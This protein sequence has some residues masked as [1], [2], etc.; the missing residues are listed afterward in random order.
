MLTLAGV[1]GCMG[2]PRSLRLSLPLPFAS[3][4]ATN[5]LEAN[6]QPT[7]AKT[8]SSCRKSRASAR[9]PRRYPLLQ[10]ALLGI[11]DWLAHPHG[12]SCCVAHSIG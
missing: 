8:E 7:Q 11:G 6:P 9:Y 3:R 2:K 12:S 5:I 1:S 10:G 4:F